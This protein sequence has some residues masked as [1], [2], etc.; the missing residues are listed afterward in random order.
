MA[1][2]DIH[3]DSI[4]VNNNPATVNI[5]GLDN[6]KDTLTMETPQPLKS[7]TKSEFVFPQPFQT[8]T[9]VELNVPLPIQTVS[10]AELDIKPLVFDQCLTIRMEPLPPTRIRQPYQTHFGFTLFG[11][12]LFGF[13]LEGENQTIVTDIPRRP[14]VSWGSEQAGHHPEPEQRHFLHESAA[15]SGSPVRGGL[16]IRLGD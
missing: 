5:N 12:E 1:D 2:F 15:E 7:E 13:N 10:R 9:K 14:Q 6:I 11:V 8:D 4:T 16:R 3:Y